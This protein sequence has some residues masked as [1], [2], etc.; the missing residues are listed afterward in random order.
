MVC[1]HG[2]FS[3]SLPA[4][5][6]NAHQPRKVIS[7]SSWGS[8]TGDPEV[9]LRQK[10]QL[11]STSKYIY[12]LSL[13]LQMERFGQFNCSAGYSQWLAQRLPAS[14][15]ISPL[16][17]RQIQIIMLV[18]G[19]L[20]YVKMS[21]TSLIIPYLIVSMIIPYYPILILVQ[22]HSYIYIYMYIYICVLIYIYYIYIRYIYTIYIYIYIYIYNNYN[23]SHTM[24]CS[25][26][27]I[28]C[29]Q[30]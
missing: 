6:G 15:R 25:R 10:S 16:F 17:S 14:V 20:K 11:D 3:L 4:K 5:K 9:M 28:P 12:N 8:K 23:C 29:S 2:N 19:T 24:P 13:T 27:H 7:N 30:S 1:S 21:H 18:L 22:S 26:R